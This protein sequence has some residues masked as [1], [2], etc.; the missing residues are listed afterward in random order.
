MVITH[1]IYVVYKSI[2]KD[3]H[4]VLQWLVVNVVWMVNASALQKS[5]SKEGSRILGRLRGLGIARRSVRGVEFK[6]SHFYQ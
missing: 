4:Q 2:I 3:F 6:L 5:F 1:V